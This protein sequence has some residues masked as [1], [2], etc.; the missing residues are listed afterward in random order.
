MTVTPGSGEV[1][2]MTTMKGQDVIYKKDMTITSDGKRHGEELAGDEIRMP[3]RIAASI[4]T[5]GATYVYSHMDNGEAVYIK[6]GTPK[7]VAPDFAQQSTA[8]SSG[9]GARIIQRSE[10]PDGAILHPDFVGRFYTVGS[11]RYRMMQPVTKCD[12]LFV[13]VPA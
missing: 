1:A 13:L 5:G 8:E 7:A 6:G 3:Y 4:T 10:L 2:I 12:G 11:Q 9:D